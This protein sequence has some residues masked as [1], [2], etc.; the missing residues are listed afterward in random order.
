M[1]GTVRAW[2]RYP[3]SAVGGPRALPEPE[4]SIGTAWL[5][6]PPSPPALPSVLPSALSN[7]KS[8]AMAHPP[9]MGPY[10]LAS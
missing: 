9:T 5:Q 4:P 10:R 6:A 1:D 7:H 2:Q 8:S 3:G